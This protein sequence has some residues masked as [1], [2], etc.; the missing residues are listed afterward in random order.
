MILFIYLI[1]YVIPYP[2]RRQVTLLY[3]IYYH[4]H[5]FCLR[6]IFF[7]DTVIKLASRLMHVLRENCS[8]RE[9]CGNSIDLGGASRTEKVFLRLMLPIFIRLGSGRPGKIV[10]EGIVSW[11]R[12]IASIRM[13]LFV[14]YWLHAL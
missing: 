8:L 1:C 3:S 12:G 10:N 13:K 9:L 5:Q 4:S 2:I 7:A 11:C 6:P 14:R